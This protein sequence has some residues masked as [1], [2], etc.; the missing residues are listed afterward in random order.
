MY[1]LVG[2]DLFKLS[3]SALFVNNGLFVQTC[4]KLSFTNLIESSEPKRIWN[5]WF[6]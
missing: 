5:R 2:F 3:Y 4:N 1:V 6:Y